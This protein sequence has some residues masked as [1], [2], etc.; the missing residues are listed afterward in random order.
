[1]FMIIIMN[2]IVITIAMTTIF[3]CVSTGSYEDPT[4]FVDITLDLHLSDLMS[5]TDLQLSSAVI[6]IINIIIVK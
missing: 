4:K 6:I 3:M 2:N 5:P 1:M